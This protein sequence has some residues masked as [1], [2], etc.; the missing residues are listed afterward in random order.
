MTW[1]SLAVASYF[2]TA[3]ANIID[4]L[5][6]TKYLKAPAIYAF[7]VGFLGILAIV[8]LPFGVTLPA[9]GEL[10]FSLLVGAGFIISLY[11]MYAG[12]LRGETTRVATLIGGSLPIYTF[13]LSYLFL[14]E[15]LD[16]NELF[17]FIFLIAGMAVLSSE[18]VV[19]S[20]RKQRTNSYIRIALI[21][22][23]LFSLTFVGTDL[24][25]TQQS[26]IA[27][28]FWMRMGAV[29]AALG[30]LLVPTWR[31]LIVADIKAP[32][33]EQSKSKGLIMTNQVIGACGFILLNLAIDA[34][35][36][37]LV[38]A[39]QGLQYVFI[40]ILAAVIGRFVPEVR[41]AATRR[42][43]IEKVV[44]MILIM[45]GLVFLAM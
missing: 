9:M 14:G 10:L 41:E 38:N 19:R 33:Q 44:A 12:F 1:L 26:F 17:A 3:I 35:S 43:V 42:S 28:F 6:L 32:Q 37:T 30:L 16:M 24:V 34:G 25:Y 4:K 40:F 8:L 15:R 36:V 39:M 20:V 18:A 11:V 23:L 21:A 7:Y 45:T 31:K 22:G 2:F 29:L 27:G 5:V 13:A